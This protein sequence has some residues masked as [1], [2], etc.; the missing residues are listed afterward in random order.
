MSS[1]PAEQRNAFENAIARVRS[2]LPENIGSKRFLLSELLALIL[3]LV[4]EVRLQRNRQ[5]PA[6]APHRLVSAVDSG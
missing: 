3:I 5:A 6:R 1:T 4:I 2:S